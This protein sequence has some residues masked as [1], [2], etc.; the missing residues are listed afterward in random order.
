MLTTHS[1]KR[2]RE[3]EVIG[4]VALIVKKYFV[5]TGVLKNKSDFSKE[6]IENM[7]KNIGGLID[8]SIEV[9]FVEFS[10]YGLEEQSTTC[11]SFTKGKH[12]LQKIGKDKFIVSY[13]KDSSLEK[14]RFKA[15][16]ELAHFA[17]HWN[18]MDMDNM[19]IGE[20][21]YCSDISILE[22]DAWDFAHLFIDSLNKEHTKD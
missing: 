7:F 19:E 15:M 8:K 5:D 10:E 16:H 21:F 22:N 11:A 1:N 17:L 9:D 3:L 4:N 14:I 2:S 12:F 6:T 13:C 20:R 18:K